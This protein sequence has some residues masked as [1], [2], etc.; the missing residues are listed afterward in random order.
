MYNSFEVGKETS[1]HTTGRRKGGM[2]KWFFGRFFD[3]S[4][5]F[6]ASSSSVFGG[7]VYLLSKRR[8][9]KFEKSGVYFK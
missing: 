3:E 6:I 5:H 7:L 1:F 8:W 2:G 4:S 9:P